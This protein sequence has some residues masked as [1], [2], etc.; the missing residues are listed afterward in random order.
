MDDKTSIKS[1]S[2]A[3]AGA[4][5]ASS[6]KGLS[7]GMTG[8]FLI[9]QMAGAGFLA[10]PR[11]LADTGWLGIGMMVIFCV[12]VAFVGTRLGRCWIIL[13]ERWPEQY[14][15]NV[16]QPYMDIAE[17]SMG[18]TGRKI[19][20]WSVILNLYGS[21]TVHM[22]L[23]SE[24]LAAVVQQQTG[25]CVLT[26]CHVI[27][28]VGVCLIPLTW[29]GSPKDFWQGSILAVVATIVA[30]VVIVIEIFVN[31]EDIETPSYPNPTV[32]S[33][34]LGF[35]AILF[36][37]GGAAVF[38]TIQN[39]MADRSQFWKSIILGFSGILS[40]YMPVALVGYIKIGDAVKS[41]ILLSVDMTNAVLVAICMEIV[42]LL[43]TFVISSNPVHQ[44][45]EELFHVPNKFGPKR[46]LVRSSLV[47]V[48]I[49]IG[50]AVPNFGTILNL[51]GGS[52]I[53]LCTFILPPVMYMKLMDDKSDKT[54]IERV[55]PLWERVYLCEVIAV[56][57][58]GGVLSTITAV[59]DVVEASFNNSCFTFFSVCEELV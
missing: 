50:L 41:N 40:L 31:G 24:M 47:A 9:A 32:A 20:L 44:S 11:G 1:G 34:S 45:I 13:E 17:R 49:L 57:L 58:V 22:I 23:I 15:S 26:K 27:I 16:R 25:E 10:L 42:N 35:G 54:G 48:Q 37:F 29:L 21:T 5:A 56:G 8:F 53:T 6:Q 46:V 38:P 12:S 30:V 2:V 36:A 51:I 4:A 18:Q 3:M 52:L 43:C 28:I 39:D 33:F 55:I 14:K 19:T 59:F 7:M